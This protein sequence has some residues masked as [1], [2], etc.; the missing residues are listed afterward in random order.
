MFCLFVSQAMSKFVYMQIYRTN[1]RN[2]F[3]LV[4]CYYYTLLAKLSDI[5]V[6]ILNL[7]TK[8]DYVFVIFNGSV[9]AGG[10]MGHA[11]PPL[12]VN[13]FLQLL[14]VVAFF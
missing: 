2:T 6:W 13:G 9:V 10:H 4:C 12:L 7:N 1:L 8:S 11:P 3:A 14:Y 5:H